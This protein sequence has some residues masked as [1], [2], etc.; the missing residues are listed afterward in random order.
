MKMTRS[1]RSAANQKY[2]GCTWKGH[3][4]HGCCHE[5]L[6]HI[7]KL[8]SSL[9]SSLRIHEQAFTITFFLKNDIPSSYTLFYHHSKRKHQRDPQ[10]SPPPSGTY[11]MRVRSRR[12]CSH[13]PQAHQ[14]SDKN[15]HAPRFPNFPPIS[16][17]KRPPPSQPHVGNQ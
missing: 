4:C 5:I 12:K 1:C 11:R 17:E 14:H 8:S 6:S 2:G 9:S 13:S 15:P 10:T 3:G 16:S 7:L